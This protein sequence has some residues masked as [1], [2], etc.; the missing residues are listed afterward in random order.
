MTLLDNEPLPST[1]FY[2]VAM[3]LCARQTVMKTLTRGRR[4]VTI[5]VVL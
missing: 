2:N 3:K 5:A 1:V 4:F